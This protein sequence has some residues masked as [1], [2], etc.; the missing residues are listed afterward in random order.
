MCNI[1]MH[2]LANKVKVI[3]H[4]MCNMVKHAL[5]ANKVKVI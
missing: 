2:A 3:E 4:P 1:I 5:I